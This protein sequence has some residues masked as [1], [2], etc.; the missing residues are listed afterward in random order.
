MVISRNWVSRDEPHTYPE[1]FG[2]CWENGSNIYIC[3]CICICVCTYVY[4]YIYPIWDSWFV[5]VMSHEG[6]VNIFEPEDQRCWWLKYCN[7]LCH[8][9]IFTEKVSNFWVQW[10]QCDV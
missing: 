9:C 3:I 10:L 7:Q 8:P 6:M 4:I 1:I 5:S 2:K